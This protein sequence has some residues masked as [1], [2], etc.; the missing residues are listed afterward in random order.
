MRHRPKRRI[1]VLLLAVAISAATACKGA[2]DASGEPAIPDRDLPL[3]FPAHA[4]V[5]RDD[6]T[7]T[8]R[9]LSAPDLSSDLERDPEFR[10]AVEDGRFGDAA[11]A[12]VSHY[13]RVF[14]L[15]DP[16]RELRIE[17]VATDALGRTHVRLEQSYRGIPVHGGELLVHLDGGNVYLAQ[18]HY[19]LTPS[20]LDTV[21][22]LTRDEALAATARTLR[23]SST[24]AF[25]AE[26][27][28][29]AGAARPRL[30]YRVDAP[31]SPSQGWQVMVAADSG[32]I[33]RRAPTVYPAGRG[34]RGSPDAVK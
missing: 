2:G 17:S 29:F 28:I 1:A 27:S 16:A 3:A 21:P 5:L 32:E 13:R 15:D 18:G 34:R 26:L 10:E 30:A 23:V 31:I 6:R 4:E 8:I 24:A 25:R 19:I 14:G 7:G 11:L 20:T 22:G 33:L 12:F 9:F